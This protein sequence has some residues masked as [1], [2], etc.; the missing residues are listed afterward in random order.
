[1][2]T[3]THLTALIGR[4]SELAEIAHLLGMPECRLITL[5]GS[6]GIG[7][8]RLALE[9]I[10]QN[11]LPDGA[12]FVPLQSYSSAD[13]IVPAIAD[14]LKFVFFGEHD[15]RTQLLYYLREKQLLLVLDNFEHLLDGADFLPEIL[16]AAPGIKILVTSRERL[17]LLEEWVLDIRGLRF[18]E[19]E[20]N[21]PLSSYSSVLLFTQSARR[22]GYMPQEK[23]AAAIIRICQSLEGVPLAIE[24]AAGWA[25]AMPCQQIADEI[26]HNLD[27]L[28]SNLRNMPER[29]RSMRA[30]FD[31]SWTLLSDDEK[32]AFMKLSVFRGGFTREAA[33]AVASASL[34]V[35]VSLVNKSLARVTMNGR[36]DLHELLRQFGAE[37]LE[38]AGVMA[39]TQD[40][41]NAYYADFIAERE[42][43]LKGRRQLEAVAEINADFENI[44]TAWNQQ[45]ARRQ[46]EFIAKMIEGLHV[47]G[48]ISHQE[49]KRYLLFRDA[50]PYF[51]P[52]QDEPDSQL[53]GRLLARA[54]DE[55]I[56]GDFTAQIERA[57]QIARQ[58]G[59]HGE[60]GYCLWA[61]GWCEAADSDISRALLE[62]SLIYFR[63]AQDRFATAWVLIDLAGLNYPGSWE[64]RKRYGEESLQLNREIGSR[65]GIAYSLYIAALS[66]IREGNFAEAEKLWLERIAVARESANRALE[67]ASLIYL[68]EK[69]YL[70]QGEIGKARAAVEEALQIFYVIDFGL[71]RGLALASLGLLECVD[72]HYEQGLALFRQAASHNTVTYKW[73]PDFISW[74]LAI[75]ACGRG[76]YEAARGYFPAAYRYYEN[77]FGK[78]GMLVCLPVPAILHAHSGNPTRAVELLALAY[79]HPLNASGWMKKWPLLTRLKAEL[80]ETLGKE[81]YAAVWERGKRL[82]AETMM[83]GL[84]AELEKPSGN[85]QLLNS[86]LLSNREQEIVRL[87]V[88]GLSN[89]EIADKLF[90]SLETI[91]W[92]LK[93]I[94]SKLDIH[95]REELISRFGL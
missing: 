59:D 58:Y 9:A 8:T 37:Q 86:D 39:L 70:I 47:F 38:G 78:L 56:P 55:R 19:Q 6:G 64:D 75:A 14:E 74:G 71:Y 10:H 34:P 13:A 76:D 72:E 90:L 7:K 66:K 12:Y 52:I 43:D 1:M 91:R 15:A 33:E 40:G 80:E 62:Q 61:L 24:L 25:R 2:T 81:G 89:R 31:H 21:Q 18:P 84:L 85:A 94:Y 60:I 22:A 73:I 51:A 23:D 45:A 28:S 17:N 4:D 42:S 92:Y 65:I 63:Q 69:N 49:E 95:S 3:P 44:R 93:E 16:D 29:H 35:L 11:A 54:W 36:Y 32:N 67:A 53:W 48:W 88:N 57:L 50:E 82:D 77:V 30:A 46:E 79:T 26:E 41:H 68:C 20:P 27:I 5:T 83:T 87:A